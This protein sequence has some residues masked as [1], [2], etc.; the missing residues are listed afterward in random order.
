[1]NKSPDGVYEIYLSAESIDKKTFSPSSPYFINVLDVYT[2]SSGKNKTISLDITENIKKLLQVNSNPPSYFVTLL[3]RG[4]QLKD[5]TASTN[6]GELKIGSIE[7]AAIS[8]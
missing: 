8:N 3:F 5:N 6:A 1:L 7:I 4:N 2:I